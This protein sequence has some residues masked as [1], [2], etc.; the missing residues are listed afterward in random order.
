MLQPEIFPEL[1]LQIELSNFSS[2]DVSDA[3]ARLTPDMAYIPAISL[4][5]PLDQTTRICGPAYTA[6]FALLD[7]PAPPIQIHH[8]DSAPSGSVVVYKVPREAPNAVWGGLM[9]TRAIHLGVVGVVVEGYIRDLNEHREIA[10]PVFA[11]GKLIYIGAKI[12][13]S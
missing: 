9:T 12:S 6:E 2:S 10:F 3:L 13:R 1:S 4:M 5:S 8:L 11:S 7:H